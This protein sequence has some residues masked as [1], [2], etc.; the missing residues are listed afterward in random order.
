MFKYGEALI[1]KIFQFL[2][3]HVTHFL[4]FF[5]LKVKQIYTILFQ[6]NMEKYFH[7]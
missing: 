4:I 6:P 2:F 3:Y 7:M 5:K 1:N